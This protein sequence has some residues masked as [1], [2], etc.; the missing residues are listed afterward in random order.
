M[1]DHPEASKEEFDLAWKASENA[2]DTHKVIIHTRTRDYMLIIP[3]IAIQGHVR[4]TNAAHTL[5]LRHYCIQ[6]RL[7][8]HARQVRRTGL[9]CGCVLSKE[10]RE[11]SRAPQYQ[12]HLSCY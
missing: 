9:D 3:L 5:C 2:E 6:V 7:R 11:V 8:W 12:Y 10:D 1:R 4:T